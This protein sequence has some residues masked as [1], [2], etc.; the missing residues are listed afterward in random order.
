MP[1]LR[2]LQPRVHTI[3]SKVKPLQSPDFSRGRVEGKRMSGRRLQN[4]RYL[5]WRQDPHCKGCGKLVR[6]PCGFELD[7]IV[8]LVN[9][10]T[11][12][13]DNLQILCKGPGSCHEAKTRED[14][15]R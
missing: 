9:G 10:G 8:A 13:A 11:D 6:Y 2:T 7:H 3:G 1:K 5:M 14:L 4:A 15:G 12:E